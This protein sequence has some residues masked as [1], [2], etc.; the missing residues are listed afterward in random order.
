MKASP[1]KRAVN[2]ADKYF[3]LYIRA[4][5]KRC[6]TCGSSDNLQCG[7]LF[8]RTYYT[9]RWD[10]KNAFCQCAGCNLR[11]EHDPYKLTSHFMMVFSEEEY[12]ELHSQLQ[13]VSKKTTFEIEE[14]GDYYKSKWEEIK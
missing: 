11:H 2:R 14:I 7:H 5:D 4:R 1:R 8:T 3:S 9:L 13:G 12:H 6:V 10:E